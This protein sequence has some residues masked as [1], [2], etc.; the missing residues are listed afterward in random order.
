MQNQT[1]RKLRYLFAVIALCGTASFIFPFNPFSRIQIV[2]SETNETPA[3]NLKVSFEEN[4]GQFDRRVRFAARTAGA[5]IFLTATEVV[6]V[7]P[8]EESRKNETEKTRDCENEFTVENIIAPPCRRVSASEA[9]ALRMRIVGANPDSG[10][11][12]EQPR[13]QLTNYFKGGESNWKTGIPNFGSVRFADVYEGISMVWYGKENGATRYDFVVGP[14]ADAEQIALEFDGADRIETSPEGHLLI[15]TAAG[16]I[17]QEKPFT[18]QETNGLRQEIESGFAVEG[19]RVRF[20]LGEYDRSKRLVI[21]PTVTLNN[22]AFS[23]FLGSFQDDIANDIAVDAAGNTYITGRTASSA[24]P[25]TTGVFDTSANGGDDVF[26]TKINATGTG[27]VF[28]TFLG[29]TTFDEGRGIAIETNGNI[30]VAGVAGPNFPTNAGAYDTTFNGGSDVFVTKLSPNGSAI[31]YST[32]IGASQNESANDLAI[33]ADGNAYIVVRAAD[34]GIAI[35]YPTTIGAFDTTHNGFDDVAVTKINPTGTALVYSTFLGGSSL[36]VGAAITVNSAGEVFVGGAT[37]DDVADFPTT[38]GAFDTTHNGATDFFVTKLNSA[39]T[40]LI[41]STFIGGTGIDNGAGLAIDNVGSAYIVGVVAQGFPT[42]PG[43]FDTTASGSTEIGVSKLSANGATLV[44]STFLGG[45]QGENGTSVAVDAFGNAYVLGTNFGGDYPTTGGAYDTTYNGNNDGVLTVLNPPATALISS[46]Y[47]GGGGSDFA[48]DI[49]LDSA[50]N[51]YVTGQ[52]ALNANPF[53]TTANAFQTF[54]GGGADAFIS[55][56]GDFAIAGRVI[57]TS[58]NPLPNV[59]IALSGQVSGFFLTGADGRFGFLDTV[60]GEPHAVSATRSGYLINPSIFNIANLNE[61]REL[62]FVGTPGSPTGGTG[63]TLRFENLSYNKTENG[64]AISISVKRTGTIT[65]NDPVTVDFQTVDGTA[66]AGQ[67]YQT[68]TGVLTFNPFEMSKTINIPILNDG[69]L[70]PREN[71][72]LVLSNPTNN[73]EIEAN[74]GTTQVQILD[75][76]LSGSDLLISEFR[77]RGRLGANDEYVKLFN[78]NDFDITVQTADG[79]DGLTL[80]RSEGAELTPVVTIP[81]LVTI[82]SRGHYL[83]TNNN[84][85]GGFSLIDYPTGRGTTIAVGD[86]TFAVDIPDNSNLVLLKTSEEKNFNP[87]NLI[88]AVGFGASDWTNEGKT[89]PLIGAANTEMSFVRRLKSGGIQDTNSNAADFL[90]V[91]HHATAF[92][93]GNQ[94]KIYAALGSPAPETSESLR[95]MT[96]NEISIEEFGAET[97]DPTPVP[98]GAQGT[99]TVY[100]R[101]T[102]NTNQPILALRLRAIDFPTAGTL[103]QKRYSSRPDFR[104]LSSPDESPTVKGVTLAAERLQPNGGGL[105]STLTVDAIT[106]VNPLL[107]N[108][109]VVVAIR[110]GVMRYGRHPISLAVEALQ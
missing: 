28:S 32:Y 68:T 88:D 15:Y 14:E 72:S 23:T 35:P 33:D 100:R 25:T 5:N 76:D 11:A 37:T 42:T 81:N 43:V 87:A 57:D 12:G 103:L 47:L 7:L 45:T 107:P 21:D 27:I 55:K 41:Y 26:V 108:Q 24:F 53:P 1:I 29:G 9:F 80:V 82:A 3:E 30:Y 54:N 79:S 38:A 84:P 78:P 106:A 2:K 110:F 39:G 60:P 86:Q 50:G 46:T 17:K 91:D 85:N 66:I 51:V 48:N 97:Y 93:G 96:A 16:I 65:T 49:A 71:F 102:N 13:E 98:N 10:F 4:R 77:Q 101:I 6:Y 8:L 83:L 52:T 40:A 63:G 44:Y 62:I 94:T 99:L 75:E 92:D 31:I 19:N 61:N 74:R 89:L 73:S 67:D 90:L 18:Y 58:G 70:E 105:N 64:G 95:L 109:S 22:L 20:T 59:M 69:T 104:L 36:D 34:T 56:F